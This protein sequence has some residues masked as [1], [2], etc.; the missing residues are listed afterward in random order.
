MSD[1]P[2][3]T[4]NMSRPWKSLAKIAANKAHSTEEVAE[5][6]RPALLD[7]WKGVR[8]AFAQE[9]RAALGD[10][11]HGQLFPT[12]SLAETQ[13][14]RAAACSPMEALLADQAGEVARDGHLG[15]AAFQAA[16]QGC[17]EDRALQRARQM[18]EHYLRKSSPDAGRLRRQLSASIAAVGVDQLAAGIAAGAGI[19]SLAPKTDRSG[20]DEGVP[21]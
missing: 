20:I 10:N 8:P 18:E 16:V 21:L 5:A 3:K 19:R 4:L 7:D 12:I 9:I 13:R 11:D 17:L 14:L 1:G 6:Y 2:Y 15:G